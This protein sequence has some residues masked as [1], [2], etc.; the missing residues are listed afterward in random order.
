MDFDNNQRRLAVKISYF[1][2]PLTTKV[3]KEMHKCHKEL[4]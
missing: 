1:L 4:R 3:T 2:Q